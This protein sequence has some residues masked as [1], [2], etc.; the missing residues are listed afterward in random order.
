MPAVR[1]GCRGGCGPWKGL[2]YFQ[3]AVSP[4][5]GGIPHL[6]ATVCPHGAAAELRVQFKASLARTWSD[7]D[8]RHTAPFIPSLLFTKGSY[9]EW[10]SFRSQSSVRWLP[11]VLKPYHVCKHFERTKNVDKFRVSLFQNC[12]KVERAGP[13]VGRGFDRT[14]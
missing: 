4:L 3:L 2:L 5:P 12:E 14:G 13:L 10:A 9:L 6:S 11:P 8:S 1:L 7:I